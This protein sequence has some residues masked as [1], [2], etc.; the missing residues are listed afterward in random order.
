MWDPELHY[1][2]VVLM[3]YDAGCYELEEA[4]LGV[5]QWKC[6]E[7]LCTVMYSSDWAPF[8]LLWRTPLLCT[9]QNKTTL[10]SN[11]NKNPNVG[12]SDIYL[13]HI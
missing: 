7:P 8:G 9:D 10:R 3:P 6:W 4:C 13:S 11:S 12:D 1:C 2:S 5:S